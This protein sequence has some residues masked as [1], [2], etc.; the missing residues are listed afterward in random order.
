ML[1][2]YLM[3]SMLF[4]QT[5]AL[6]QSPP[7]VKSFRYAG[8]T[9]PLGYFDPLKISYN[10]NEKQLQYLR[11]AEL[12]HARVAMSSVLTFPLIEYFYKDE[13]AVNFLAHQSVI[14][15]LPY[16]FS[17]MLFEVARMRTYWKD[18]F[19]TDKFFSIKDNAQPGNVFSYEKDS[20]R[21]SSLNKELNN[22]R[23]AM[24]SI[25]YMMVY[26]LYTQHKIFDF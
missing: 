10:K 21:N 8:A 3:L 11:E 17:I 24:L 12:Q 19:K 15:Q 18:P 7:V 9:S 14:T 5:S 2:K 26:E 23:L 4:F 22:G 20:L 1:G 6:T 25:A 13:L 16:W